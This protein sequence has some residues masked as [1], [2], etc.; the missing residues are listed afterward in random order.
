MA[1]IQL[2]LIGFGHWPQ[3]AYVPTLT[4]H[5]GVRVVAV[6][7]RSQATR[8]RARQTFG[9]AVST[10]ADYQDLLADPAVDAVMVAVPNAMHREVALAALG[11]RKHLFLELP[12]ALTPEDVGA[13]LAAAEAG[14]QVV[15]L[16]FELRYMPVSRAV[17]CLILEGEMGRPLSA[18]VE[19]RCDWAFEGGHFQEPTARDGFYPWLGAWYLDMLDLLLGGPEPLRTQVAGGRAMNGP[20]L[21]YGHALIEYASGAVG[22]FC[23]TLVSTRPEVSVT[24]NL[25]CERGELAVDFQAGTLVRHLKG[26]ETVE[27]ACPPK[28]P[29]T[30]WAGMRE[31]IEG[32]LAAVRGQEPGLADTGVARRVH[33]AVFACHEADRARR[34]KPVANVSRT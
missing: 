26:G 1:A 27:T 16:D 2:G 11:H 17:E 28:Q 7:A 9:C 3:E 24:G 15:Q 30:G 12:V 5:N 19:L 31:S 20:L 29:V 10:P 22:R 8:E 33:G 23:H 18:S 32:F 13:V 14:S 4:G 25:L 21:D 34:G 6:A